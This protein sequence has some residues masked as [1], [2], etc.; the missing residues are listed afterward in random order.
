MTGFRVP[1][2]PG[3]TDGLFASG[4]WVGFYTYPVD[5][6]KHWQE[7]ELRFHEGLLVGEGTDDIGP[8]SLRGE[9]DASSGECWW[10]KRYRDP[11]L[12]PVYYRGRH[13]GRRIAGVWELPGIRGGFRIWPKGMPEGEWEEEEVEEPVEEEALIGCTL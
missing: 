4:A 10:V 9:Y 12:Y 8:F 1:E 5:P 7:L 6:T 2:V 3:G 11:T 13:N